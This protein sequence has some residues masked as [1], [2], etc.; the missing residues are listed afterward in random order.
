M[1][2]RLGDLY[3]Q[4]PLV[5]F[6]ISGSTDAGRAATAPSARTCCEPGSPTT[7]SGAETGAD[8]E[9]QE[10]LNDLGILNDSRVLQT[11]W[12]PEMGANVF[13]RPRT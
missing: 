12:E 5:C 7:G 4:S 6:R 10:A 3:R 1:C 2:G 13:S 9:L 11:L 8:I